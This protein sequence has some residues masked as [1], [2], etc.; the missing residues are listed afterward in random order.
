[1]DRRNLEVAPSAKGGGGGGPGEAGTVRRQ[2]PDTAYWNAVVRTDATGHAQVKVV[3]PDTLTTWNM[4]VKAVTAD[5]EVGEATVDVK[6]TKPLHV[7][8]V[9]PRFFVVGDKANVGAIVHNETDN[10]F[11]VQVEI[12]ADGVDV[13]RR[14][15]DRSTCR[16]TVRPG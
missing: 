13:T 11:S 4:S 1:M 5:T 16:R 3:L 8:S 6:S 10:A 9:L 7:R 14:Y 12:N 15:P 2:F